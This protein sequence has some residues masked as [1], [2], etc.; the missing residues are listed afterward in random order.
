MRIV[1]AIMFLV[2]VALQF[3]FWRGQGSV[4]DYFRLQQLVEQQKKENTN[5]TMRNDLLANE[6]KTLKEGDEAIEEHARNEL[7]LV[8]KNE[9]FYHIIEN[10]K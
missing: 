6:V 5:L 2:F 7:G 9:T 3:D 1:I 10:G 4:I 8:K